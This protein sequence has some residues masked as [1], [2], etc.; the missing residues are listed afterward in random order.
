M[1]DP[2]GLGTHKS[3]ITFSQAE[4]KEFIHQFPWEQISNSIA[5]RNGPERGKV[6]RDVTRIN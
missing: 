6:L 1:L 3:P 4:G 5:A 2:V